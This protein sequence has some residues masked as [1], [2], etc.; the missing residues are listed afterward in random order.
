M[1][2]PLPVCRVLRVLMLAVETRSAHAVRQRQRLI[3][4]WVVALLLLATWLGARGLNADAIWYD[5]YWSLFGAGGTHRGPYTLA[6]TVD[7]LAASSHER[8]PPFY[9]LAL[10]LW[11]HAT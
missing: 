1:L 3:W 4:L 6:Q 10:N 11:G 9:Y 8:S 2:Y 7:S 5:E